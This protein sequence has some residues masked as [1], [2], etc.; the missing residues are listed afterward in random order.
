MSV[1][2]NLGWRCR[3]GMKELDLLMSGYLQEDYPRAPAAER[4]A[5]EKLLDYQDP[6]IV[7][8]LFRRCVDDDAAI[9][10][11]ID[12]LRDKSI[13]PPEPTP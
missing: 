2:K 13:L 9:N 8:L 5:F 12:V 10:A 3:R 7:D 11:L 4:R 1:P 6:L